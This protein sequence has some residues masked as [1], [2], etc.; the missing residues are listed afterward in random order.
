MA[1]TITNKQVGIGAPQKKGSGFTNLNRYLQENQQ[2]R[3]GTAVTSGITKQAT[4][5]KEELNKSK[6]E[7]QSGLNKNQIG[8]QDKQ[9]VGGILG[10]AVNASD[11]DVAYTKR[12]LAGP[13][14]ELQTLGQSGIKDFAAVQAQAQQAQQSA[15][16]IGSNQGRLALLQ[17][18]AGGP[19]YTQGQQR[20]DNLLFG[21]TADKG[22]LQ[23]ARR[24][25][26][27]LTQQAQSAQDVARGQASQ[28]VDQAKQFAQDTEG[29]RS[30]LVKGIQTDL[31]AK[32]NQFN[33]KRSEATNAYSAL[34]DFILSA[35]QNSPNYQNEL[36]DRERQ[37]LIATGNLDPG[38]QKEGAW[39]NLGGPST[40]LRGPATPERSISA[41][42]SKAREYGFSPAQTQELLANTA[43]FNAGD[44]ADVTGS[45]FM[46]EQEAAQL[47]ALARLA[48]QD[49]SAA[50]YTGAAPKAASGNVE[51]DRG[52]NL[53][54]Q[55]LQNSEEYKAAQTTTPAVQS[56]MGELQAS[57][58]RAN[59]N[60]QHYQTMLN[61]LAAKEQAGTAVYGDQ[62]SRAFAQR[63]LEL[64]KKAAVDNDAAL[65]E[66][67]SMYNYYQNIMNRKF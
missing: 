14:N 40:G 34:N 55:Y 5:A 6:D 62:A 56:A 12:I 29:K 17:R 37:F 59:Q 50:A 51:Y 47:N 8:E 23:G 63:Q 9:R 45:Q 24:Q 57:V 3:L 19:Q 26:L 1:D 36:M 25:A 2:N 32:A 11:D 49:Q 41:L 39:G 46:G 18:F 48:G 4:S 27:G 64:A 15:Q 16:N 35:D 53:G 28:A 43:Q 66:Q 31:S 44:V 52:A 54:N 21:A 7:F 61:D 67:Q 33:N 13:T 65:K 20:L 42:I 10:N 58:Q 30:G 38:A 22:A 60:V